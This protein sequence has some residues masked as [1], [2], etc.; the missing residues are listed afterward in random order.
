MAVAAHAARVFEACG[1][2]SVFS[3]SHI[4]SLSFGPRSGSFATKTGRSTQSEFAPVAWFVLDPSK[5]QMP[6]LL[7]VG[8]DLGL[9][10]HER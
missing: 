6:G 4:T 10:A 2:M 7:A 1:V 3:T 9:A 5:P 8:D